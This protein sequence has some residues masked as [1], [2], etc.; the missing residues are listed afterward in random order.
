MPEMTTATSLASDRPAGPAGGRADAAAIAE[1]L[2]SPSLTAEVGAGLRRRRWPVRLALLL[3]V[4]AVAAGAFVWLAGALQ[5]REGATSL[6]SLPTT[7]VRR[8]ELRISVTEEGS[9]VSDEN[10]DIV[11]GVAGGAT[12][13]WLIDDG[14]RVTEG[15]EI[16]RL[17]DSTIA[18]NVTAQKIAFEKAR[19]AMIQAEKDHAAGGIA[20]EE[21][22]EGTFKKELRTAESSVSA[23]TEW[24]QSTR[25]TLAYGER[26]FRKGY[27]SPQ[28]FD[29][30]KSAVARAELDLGT[31]EIALDVLTRFTKPKMI[32]ELESV[33]DAAAARFASE[34]AALE[35][36][37]VKLDR[38]NAQLAKCVVKAPKDGL[39][40]Y[41]NERNRDRDSEVK[42]GAMVNEG[43]TIL[44]LPN[45][46]K[47]R[48]DVEVHES[49]VDRIRPGMQASIRV[50]GREFSG[51]V[52]A[53]A[54]RPQSNWLSTAKKYVV[55]VRIDGNT[56]DLRPGFTAEVEILVADLEGVIAVPVAAVIEQHG[57]YVCA[58]R[59]GGE[60]ERRMVSLGQSNDKLVEI[61]AGL[62]EGETLFLNPRGLLP[63]SSDEDAEAEP[64]NAA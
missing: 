33:R 15:M 23:A 4:G 9:L 29:A 12:I 64:S 3:L 30:Q 7:I 26:M 51:A 1:I 17:D 25:N 60:V 16:V 31:A 44:R 62:T 54:N 50:Q 6:D 35:L 5:N 21:Y 52:T 2:G 19:A 55:E 48:A 36:E 59:Q 42:A 14:A 61:L 46:S 58:V 32:T 49:K 13:V 57:E 56:E 10:V 63:D 53:V 43:K 39:V 34:Q 20:V 22:K 18:E 11:C 37:Q 38:L 8:G 47:M 27:I 28:Q 41:A 40:I 24:L 45:L